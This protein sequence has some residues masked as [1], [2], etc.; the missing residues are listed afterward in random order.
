MYDNI[1]LQTIDFYRDFAT[2]CINN[3]SFETKIVRKDGLSYILYKSLDASFSA[4]LFVSEDVYTR[5]EA[6]TKLYT[7]SKN[8]WLSVLSMDGSLWSNINLSH[9]I[10]NFDFYGKREYFRQDK[11]LLKLYDQ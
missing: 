1:D 11:I 8:R 6:K 3:T 10:L 2:L 7:N 5:R 9:R 4:K